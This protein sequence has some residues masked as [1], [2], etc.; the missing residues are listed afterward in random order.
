MARCCCA[1]GGGYDVGR[2]ADDAGLDHQLKGA[3]KAFHVL[4]TAG[5]GGGAFRSSGSGSIGI[6]K[7]ILIG[8]FDDHT[9]L[10][11]LPNRVFSIKQNE[12][13]LAARVFERLL[14]EPANERNRRNQNDVVPS[15][16][17]CRNLS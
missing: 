6:D 4:I 12:V 2:S 7:D 13:A 8:T 16:L 3:P 15:E 1:S 9:M 17:I 10:D 11:L 5:P 14:I